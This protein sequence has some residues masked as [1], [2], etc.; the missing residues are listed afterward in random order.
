MPGSCLT[1]AQPFSR[2]EV[3]DGEGGGSEAFE[4]ADGHNG[5]ARS[6]VADCEDGGYELDW[7]SG[8]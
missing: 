6:A 1:K 2:G 7:E 4:E 5:E 8:R 3:L